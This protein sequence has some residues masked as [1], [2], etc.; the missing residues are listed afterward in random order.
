MRSKGGLTTIP[1]RRLGLILTAHVLWMVV[2]FALGAW[3]TVLAHKQ[4]TKIAMLEHAA[5]LPFEVTQAHWI[6]TQRML[7]WES[8]T[9]AILF[10]ISTG[11]LFWIYWR[12]MLRARSLHAFFASVTHELRTPL[13]SIR[14]QAESIAEGALSTEQTPS[15]KGLVDRLIEDTMRL[16]SQVERTLELARLEGGGPLFRQPLQ[17]RPWLDRSLQHWSEAF[18]GRIQFE[19]Q[20]EDTYIE[21]DPTAIQV[22]VKNILENAMRHSTQEAVQVTI[23]SQSEKKVVWLIFQDNGN[24]FSGDSSRL[25]RLFEKGAKSHGA[26]VGL[27]LIKTLMSRMGGHAEFSSGAGGF[28]VKLRFREGVPNG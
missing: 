2:V 11:L 24:G 8:T 6:K 14:L 15:Q 5:G 10:F 13:T 25:G 28:E 27:Y 26:G 20:V 21:A 19:N 23:R 3:W 12:D 7:H 17:I 9:F 16:E 22:I 4:S 1:A 18:R